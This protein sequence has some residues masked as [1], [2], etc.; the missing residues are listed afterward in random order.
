MRSRLADLVVASIQAQKGGVVTGSG[1]WEWDGTNAVSLAHSS[2]A[3]K[4]GATVVWQT[5]NSR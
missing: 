1:I 3:R 5:G 4:P 2:V